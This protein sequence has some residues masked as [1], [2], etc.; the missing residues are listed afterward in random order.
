MLGRFNKD[1][2]NYYKEHKDE[3][4]KQ[5]DGKPINEIISEFIVP[6]CNNEEQTIRKNFISASLFSNKK[7]LEAQFKTINSSEEI[8]PFQ[9]RKP[10]RL[11]NVE[12]ILKFIGDYKHGTR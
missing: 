4:H 1:A 6:E 10:V 8:E 3:I 5:S 2:L 11:T 12:E 9:H 7:D